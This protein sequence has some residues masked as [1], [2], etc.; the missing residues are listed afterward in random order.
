[1]NFLR[2]RLGDPSTNLEFPRF[3]E[4][5]TKF[6]ENHEN[7]TVSGMPGLQKIKFLSTFQILD[8][9]SRAKHLFAFDKIYEQSH[10]MS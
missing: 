3:Y 1:M 9:L 2:R 8:E 10:V 4:F 6:A 7:L 5:L